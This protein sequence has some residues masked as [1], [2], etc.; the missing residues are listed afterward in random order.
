MSLCIWIKTSEN[1]DFKGFVKEKTINWE[2]SQQSLA[3]SQFLQD[4]LS[5]AFDNKYEPHFKAFYFAEKGYKGLSG[6]TQAK[7]DWVVVF[8]TA[9]DQTAAHEFLHAFNLAHSFANQ[10][11]SS[12]AKFTY[13]SR[14][15]DNL[16]DYSHHV[17][18]H[19]NDRCSLWFWQW[20]QANKSIEK[21][22]E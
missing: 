1:E 8:N 18:G 19:E 6:Y 17:P 5:E 22:E 2:N 9:N 14:K 21:E 15:T 16:M 10:E 7:A 3:L 12:N 4:Q 20:E 13:T 11:A